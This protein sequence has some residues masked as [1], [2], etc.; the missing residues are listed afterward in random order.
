MQEHDQKIV[1]SASRRTDIPAFYMDWFWENLRSGCFHV[2]NPFNGKESVVPARP[3]DVHSIV[4]WSKDYGPFLRRN[5][6]GRL[7]DAGYRLFFNFTVNSAD[8]ILEPGVPPL[9]D[10]LDQVAGLLRFCPPEAVTWRFDPIC[11]YRT[12]PD[13][14][15]RDNLNGLMRIASHMGKLGITRCVTSFFQDYHK[16]RRRVARRAGFS[17]HFPPLDTKVEV[18]L[19]VEKILAEEGIRLAL[20][21]QKDLLAALPGG[22]TITGASC[23]DNELLAKLYGDD[24]SLLRDGGQRAAQGCG[25]KRSRDVGDYRAQ[26][27]G[28]RC[29]YCYANPGV[30]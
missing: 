1:L 10:R 9:E 18:I 5:D 19:R 4:F 30:Y 12:G 22:S 29:L 24:V 20:C 27:C 6:G 13:G 25:C 17:F 26:P 15:I 23:V 21:C 2:K 3:G 7:L 14:P 11:H 28:H 8:G 16:V